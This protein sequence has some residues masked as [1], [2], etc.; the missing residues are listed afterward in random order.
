MIKLFLRKLLNRYSSLILQEAIY[1]NGFIHLLMKPRNTGGRLTKEETMQLK[2]DLKRLSM[3]VPALI[4]FLLPGGV[5]LL[6]LL[7]ET[8]DRRKGRR[9]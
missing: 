7:A 6:P 5:L 3:Y 2:K 4:I 9:I 8:L 1:V